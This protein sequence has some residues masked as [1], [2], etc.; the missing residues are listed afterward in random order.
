MQVRAPA[1]KVD[2]K[3][4]SVVI[5]VDGEDMVVLD[6]TCLHLYYLTSHLR[7]ETS[8]FVLVHF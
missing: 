2:I 1:I 5:V 6:D 7:C 3:P 8:L 4:A